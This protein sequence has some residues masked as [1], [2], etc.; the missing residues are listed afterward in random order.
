MP[1]EAVG[2]ADELRALAALMEAG[3]PE[4]LAAA[5][6]VHGQRVAA[7]RA[8]Y[9][10]VPLAALNRRI[11]CHQHGAGGAGGAGVPAPRARTWNTIRNLDAGIILA[12]LYIYGEIGEWGITA[13]DVV[14]QLA[15]ITATNLTVYLNSAGGEVFEGQA[16]RNKLRDHPA[17]VEVR[18]DGYAAS[19]AS[20]IAM[21]GDRI[22]MNRQARMMI[23]DASGLVI[24]NPGDLRMMADIL[25]AV[26]DDMASVY[27]TRA[28]G[29]M[30]EWRKRMK[31]ETWYSADGAVEVG[32]ADEAI[33]DIPAAMEVYAGPGRIPTGVLPATVDTA[34]VGPG[35]PDPARTSQMSLARPGPDPGP[36]PLDPYRALAG[37][38]DMLSPPI[39]EAV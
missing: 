20:I 32:L 24:G 8:R 10:G 5:G 30:A 21:A 31:A 33:V 4:P 35:A 37:A 11:F 2:T 34:G 28:G 25:D 23:H 27:A 19:I 7:V 17:M 36:T 12:E 39:K 6:A 3:Q 13:A 29:T 22:V 15:S 38:L 26:S 16:I 9:P 1:I 18:V 14:A